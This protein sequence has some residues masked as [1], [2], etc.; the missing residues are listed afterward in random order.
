MS[1][2]RFV[3]VWAAEEGETALKARY[4]AEPHARRRQWLHGLWLL[5]RG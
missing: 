1:G 4:L 5:R 2:K 3:M